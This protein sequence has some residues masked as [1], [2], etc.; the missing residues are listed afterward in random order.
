MKGLAKDGVRSYSPPTLWTIS[1]LPRCCDSMGVTFSGGKRCRIQVRSIVLV[2]E[3]RGAISSAIGGFL[4]GDAWI[5]M[6]LGWMDG[7][8]LEE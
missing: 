4:V 7:K 5:R 1:A 2:V 6:R 8:A 3:V